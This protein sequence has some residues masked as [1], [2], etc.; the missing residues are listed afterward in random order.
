[1][2]LTVRNGWISLVVRGRGNRQP[3][4]TGN[5][6]GGLETSWGMKSLNASVTT[7]QNLSA[8]AWAVSLTVH[9]AGMPWVTITEM[10]ILALDTAKLWLFNLGRPLY[11][12]GDKD[13]ER[14]WLMRMEEKEEWEVERKEEKEDQMSKRKCRSMHL[15]DGGTW[16]LQAVL[17]SY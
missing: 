4:P 7:Y 10:V 11:P 1:M 9:E 8:L 17:F 16:P 3:N 13:E 15:P 14:E 5:Y 2:G 6:L 12:G